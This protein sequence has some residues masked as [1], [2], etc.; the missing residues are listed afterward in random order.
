MVSSNI[1]TFTLLAT[2]GLI[3]AIS[4]HPF[5][6]EN[7]GRFPWRGPRGPYPK[8]FE[9]ILP[10]AVKEQLKTIYE[11]KSLR[12]R[13]RKDKIDEVM[14][15][16]PQEIKE[17]LPVPPEYRD[18]PKE[19]QDQLKAI[20]LAP[21]LTRE[22]KRNKV[23]SL[24]DSLPE[25]TKKLIKPRPFPFPPM[26]PP[27]EFEEVLGT[28]VFN[29]LKNIHENKELSPSEKW[30]NV[31]E[32]MK[33]LPTEVL[34]KL[35]LPPHLRNLP[36]DIQEKLKKIFV[37]KTLSFQEKRQ[38]SRELIKTLPEEIRKSIRPPMPSFIEKLPES[39]KSQI[40]KIFKDET[41]GRREKFEKV[42]DIIDDL[43]KEERE[44]LFPEHNTAPQP[45]EEIFV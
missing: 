21:K 22:E 26:G 1:K 18:L 2:F 10:E 9:D 43:P 39:I 31:E 40:E 11:D 16:L 42:R 32:I 41:I 6:K 37:D 28:Q 14:S 5:P 35:P 23:K 27:K 3:L 19:I 38:K 4:A 45:A 20:K 44:K 30:A 13:E 33:S 34:E 15:N 17:K 7:G 29:K 8:D 25:E 12:W 36:E 24:I